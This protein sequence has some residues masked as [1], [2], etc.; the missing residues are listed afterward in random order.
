MEKYIWKKSNELLNEQKKYLPGACHYNFHGTKIIQNIVF[1]KANGSRVWDV[2][3][4]EYLDLYA[5]SGTMILGHC[6]RVVNEYMSNAL[7]RVVSVNDTIYTQEVVKKIHECF[8]SIEMM[9][10]S[11]SGT[12]A[13]QNVFR[14]ARAYT[15]K[16]KIVR[17]LGHFHGSGDNVLGNSCNDKYQPCENYKETNSTEGRF[18][19]AL[20]ETLVVPWNDY[21]KLYKIISLYEDDIAAIIMEP[22]MVNNGSIMPKEGYLQ[23][24]RKLCDTKNI[25]LIFDEV[26]TGFRVGLG[27]VQKM[28][29]VK[30]DLSIVG[31]SIS[32]GIIPL[33]VFGGKKDIM[34]LYVDQKV[35]HLGT[36]NGYPLAMAAANVTI[37]QLM[38]C[39]TYEKMGK[40][41]K[42]IKRI[43]EMTAKKMNIP[44]HLQGPLL[45]MSYHFTEKKLENYK[46]DIR[47]IAKK[48]F[49]HNMCDSYG[50]LFAAPSRIYLNTEIDDNDL[51]FFEERIYYAFDNSRDILS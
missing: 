20:E 19:G 30:P 41:A 7:E 2:D 34:Q 42:E 32:N 45:C 23:K 27:G 25:L 14:L 17:F 3:G 22:I 36:Y 48:A 8:P 47:E 5:K 24:V 9:R 37:T 18:R 46:Q 38:K 10:F 43:M 33:T 35:V 29:G 12:E 51:D 28:L 15:G 50:V 13:I 1:E 39:N 40:K 26:I 6:N 31:K 49:F 16:Q 4:N 44:F 11:L 21:E